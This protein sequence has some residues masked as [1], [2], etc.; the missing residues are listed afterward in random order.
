MSSV[1][2]PVQEYAQPFRPWFKSAA[3]ARRYK[4]NLEAVPRMQGDRLASRGERV[5]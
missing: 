1:T 3:A 4:G 5:L 2:M